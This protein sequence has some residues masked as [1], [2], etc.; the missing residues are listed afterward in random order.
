MVNDNGLETRTIA[1]IQANPDQSKHLETA[2]VKVM[3]LE[4]DFVHLRSE[5]YTGKEYPLPLVC[6]HCPDSNM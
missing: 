3:G 1:V 6:F 2:N 5:T 4:I